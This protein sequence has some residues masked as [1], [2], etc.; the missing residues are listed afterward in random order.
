MGVVA[1]GDARRNRQIAQTAQLG[2]GVR[3]QREEPNDSLHDHVGEGGLRVAEVLRKNRKH[4]RFREHGK[5]HNERGIGLVGVEGHA[6]HNHSKMAHFRRQQGYQI[7]QAAVQLLALGFTATTGPYRVKHDV[8]R[9]LPSHFVEIRCCSILEV[10][11]HL[12]R[13]LGNAWNVQQ[14]LQV[15]V[16]SHLHHQT[17]ANVEQD[18]AQRGSGRTRVE[19]VVELLRLQNLLNRAFA[20]KGRHPRHANR[21]IGGNLRLTPFHRQP[22]R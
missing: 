6:E 19:A 15:T 12:S 2:E 20:F 14:L 4:R 16:D 17:F 13:R 8:E 21:V 9:L 3:L 10:E 1:V 7:E 5:V 22:L 11:Q 18:G